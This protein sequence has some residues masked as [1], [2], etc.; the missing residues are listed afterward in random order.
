MPH[1]AITIIDLHQRRAV[2]GDHDRIVRLVK[3]RPKVLWYAYGIR[4]WANGFSATLLSTVGAKLDFLRI[5][6]LKRT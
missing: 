6:T 2:N 3:T 5:L 4:V 1:R